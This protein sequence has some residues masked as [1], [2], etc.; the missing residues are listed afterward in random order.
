V[1]AKLDWAQFSIMSTYIEFPSA[2]LSFLDCESIR[3]SL[4]D[5]TVLWVQVFLPFSSTTG[6]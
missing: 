1:K 6:L 3:I 5:P 4:D 2:I